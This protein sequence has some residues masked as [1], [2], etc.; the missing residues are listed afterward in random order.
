M[1]RKLWRILRRFL[2]PGPLSHLLKTYLAV[3]GN[4]G[5]FDRFAVFTSFRGLGFFCF[6]SVMWS[7]SRVVGLSFL[8]L[9]YKNPHPMGPKRSKHEK[10]GLSQ[11]K[12]GGGA[13]AAGGPTATDP[14]IGP[15]FCGHGGRPESRKG[16]F[17]FFLFLGPKGGQ[18]RRTKPVSLF[19]GRGHFPPP[20]RGGRP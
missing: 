20:D 14:L 2:P 18:G 3:V 11:K 13:G 16:P 5:R 9:L 19:Q 4:T 7:V 15:R 12:G 17:E 8:N 6:R 1:R 10:K